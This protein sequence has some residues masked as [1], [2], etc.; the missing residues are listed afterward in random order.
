M[1]LVFIIYLVGVLPSLGTAL[2]LLGFIGVSVSAVLL[3]LS[4]VFEQEFPE[5][6]TT[7]EKL[8]ACSYPKTFLFI[9]LLGFLIPEEKVMYTM[10]AAYG[11]QE[12]V[13]NPKV[14]ELGGKSLDVLEK[15]MDE[16]IG[17]E[18]TKEKE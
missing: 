10:L 13:T 9:W 1:S 3:F 5:G 18:E 6:D 11:V 4:F 8:R 16:Y 7:P 2:C 15:A 17:K 14:Q 12:I